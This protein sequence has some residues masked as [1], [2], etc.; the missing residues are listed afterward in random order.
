MSGDR[1]F[2]KERTL[3]IYLLAQHGDLALAREAAEETLNMDLKDDPRYFYE[4]LGMDAFLTL[5]SNLN[6]QK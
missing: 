5:V 1:D 6:P 3:R 2:L 4:V